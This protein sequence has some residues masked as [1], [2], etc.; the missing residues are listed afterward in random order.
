MG[1]PTEL[2]SPWFRVIARERLYGWWEDLDAAW[3][4]KARA[5]PREGGREREGRGGV[6]RRRAPASSSRAAPALA[7]GGA[8]DPAV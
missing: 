1:E 4:L 3:R 8:A 6:E 5:P 2:W 7:S